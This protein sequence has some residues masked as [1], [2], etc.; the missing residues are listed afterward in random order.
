MSY[1]M[2]MLVIT[3]A[4]FIIGLFI[5][6]RLIERYQRRKEINKMLNRNYTTFEHVSHSYEDISKTDSKSDVHDWGSNIRLSLI[7]I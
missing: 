4:L 6:F 5:C 7:H 2:G 3:G 1:T